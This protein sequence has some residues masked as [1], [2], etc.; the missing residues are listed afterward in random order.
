MKVVSPSSSVIPRLYY[1]QSSFLSRNLAVTSGMPICRDCIDVNRLRMQYLEFFSTAET[2]CLFDPRLLRRA[3]RATLW[4]W[5]M[6]TGQWSLSCSNLVWLD[7]SIAPCF[8]SIPV[9]IEGRYIKCYLV[10]R[11]M[12]ETDI[13]YQ[14]PSAHAAMPPFRRSEWSCMRSLQ[15]LVLIE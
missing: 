7:G 11:R 9:T 12:P 14:Q 10:C 6:G 13:V 5:G 3:Y 15:F 2:R 1:Y 4:P 8:R